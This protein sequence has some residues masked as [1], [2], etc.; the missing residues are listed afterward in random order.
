MRVSWRLDAARSANDPNGLGPVLRLR[1]TGNNNMADQLL[2]HKIQCAQQGREFWKA[3]QNFYTDGDAIAFH[4]EW[5]TYSP[6]LNTCILYEDQ[7]TKAEGEIQYFVD[8]LTGR[9][10]MTV[11]ITSKG[12]ID[13]ESPKALCELFREANVDVRVESLEGLMKARRG[14]K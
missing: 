2:A 7:H 9:D 12:Q 4:T 10:I 13:R 3:N 1:I 14:V 8:I 6:R 11:S 5:F